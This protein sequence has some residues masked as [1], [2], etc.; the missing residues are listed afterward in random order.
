M[1]RHRNRSMSFSSLEEMEAATETTTAKKETEEEE[2]E[3][4]V[5][6]DNNLQIGRASCRE[7][8]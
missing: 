5:L 8:V 2:E 1:R 6:I 7:R 4:Y 3:E